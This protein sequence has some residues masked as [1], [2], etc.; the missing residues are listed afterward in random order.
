M[1]KKYNLTRTGLLQQSGEGCHLFAFNSM[2]GPGT[3]AE[4][5]VASIKI[6]LNVHASGHCISTVVGCCSRV[7]EQQFQALAL[8]LEIVAERSLSMSHR[9]RSKFVVF[10]RDCRHARPILITLKPPRKHTLLKTLCVSPRFCFRRN[11]IPL[12]YP[13]GLEPWLWLR[14]Q[15]TDDISFNGDVQGRVQQFQRLL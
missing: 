15:R 9:S 1:K 7:L 8:S 13:P 14:W 12:R 2:F 11:E 5:I 4:C 10:I 6:T 3:A